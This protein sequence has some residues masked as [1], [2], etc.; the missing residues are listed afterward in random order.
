MTDFNAEQYSKEITAGFFAAL[1]IKSTEVAAIFSSDI[2]DQR[3]AINDW[4]QGLNQSFRDLTASDIKDVYETLESKILSGEIGAVEVVFSSNDDSEPVQDKHP[5]LR[6]VDFAVHQKRSVQAYSYKSVDWFTLQN[7]SKRFQELGDEYEFRSPKPLITHIFV[8]AENQGFRGGNHP[9]VEEALAQAIQYEQDIQD[10]AIDPRELAASPDILRTLFDSVVGE[11]RNFG[12]GGVH[13]DVPSLMKW[14]SIADE[15]LH[16][17]T[18]PELHSVYK[19]FQGQEGYDDVCSVI[20]AEISSVGGANPQ[21]KPYLEFGGM[22]SETSCD[23]RISH[24]VGGS[25]R[26]VANLEEALEQAIAEQEP[27]SQNDSIPGGP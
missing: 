21:L 10:N 5:L 15:A 6:A 9:S 16:G 14:E 12:M 11:Y 25:G 3:D 18:L 24:L 27:S 1:N 22:M 2:A 7:N 19:H 17:L 23:V 13:V 8:D 20:I 4:Y 26:F